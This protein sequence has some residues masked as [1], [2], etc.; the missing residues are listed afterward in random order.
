MYV[1]DFA[2]GDADDD[3]ALRIHRKSQELMS[4][5]D[6]CFENGIQIRHLSETSSQ[7]KKFAQKLRKAKQRS[8]NATTQMPI[9]MQ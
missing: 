3:Q 1:D 2:G 4:Q 6:S 7:H 9:L 8:Q 5:E